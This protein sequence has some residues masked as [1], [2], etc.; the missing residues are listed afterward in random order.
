MDQIPIELVSY[1][2]AYVCAEPCMTPVCRSVCKSW[3]D[4][5]HKYSSSVKPI[6]SAAKLGYVAVLRWLRE[7]R[8]KWSSRTIWAAAH[9]N[10]TEALIWLHDNGCPHE[11]NV[12]AEIVRHRN[13]ETLKS[14]RER[15]FSWNVVSCEV[16]AEQG[17]LEV[18]Q[19]LRSEGC[20]C[21]EEASEWAA[22]YGHLQIL[23]YLHSEN[24]K[25]LSE[26]IFWH[27]AL[28]GHIHILEWLYENANIESSEWGS[29]TKAAA[30]NGHINAL[31][32]LCYHGYVCDIHACKAAARS[33]YISVLQWL[34]L[35]FEWAGK[36]DKTIDAKVF[37]A[38]LK[39]GQ[40]HVV[41]YLRN[42]SETG[43]FWK[44]VHWNKQACK[45]AVFGDLETPQYPHEN[46]RQ[47]DLQQCATLAAL[48]G[49]LD[50]LQYLY[51][52]GCVLDNQVCGAAT[53]IAGQSNMEILKWLQSEGCEFDSNVLNA[54]VQYG[55]IP[56]VKWLRSQ[57][58]GLELW[59][60]WTCATALVHRH[61]K[62]FFWLIKRGCPWNPQRCLDLAEE[63]GLAEAIAWIKAKDSNVPDLGQ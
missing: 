24:P 3:Y 11:P 17:K 53:S 34:H 25:F 57:S 32:W 45:T 2:L 50:I 4:L 5:T 44:T 12:F 51:A 47:Q 39:E 31:E 62:M 20:P 58:I 10:H 56:V 49:R 40:L 1:T 42:C 63:H 29:C 37:K 33:G 22:T 46:G 15:G 55:N 7:S 23:Q 60:D 48:T 19:W 38:A 14:F 59:N 9:Y 28:G 18:L 8:H 41:R 54:A 35:Y 16:A 6:D 27:A 30:M 61:E 21:D 52:E 26:N 13:I 36:I 43:D